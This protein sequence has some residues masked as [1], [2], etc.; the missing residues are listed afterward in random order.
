[1]H[2][3]V[4]S[5]GD[6]GISAQRLR[7]ETPREVT[8]FLETANSGGVIMSSE[9]FTPRPDISDSE[10]EH[11]LS[12]PY[13]PNGDEAD[14]FKYYCPLCMQYYK[15]IWR[16]QCCS[17][18]ICMPCTKDYMKAKGVVNFRIQIQAVPL[19]HVFCPHCQSIGF[20]PVVVDRQ[21]SIR[22]YRYSYEPVSSA[23]MPSPLKVGESFEDLKRKMIPFKA[24]TSVSSIPSSVLASPV[25]Q[26]VGSES[27]RQYEFSESQSLMRGIALA[28]EDDDVSPS[29]HGNR[30]VLT[31]FGVSPRE[32][33]FAN[34][35][36]LLSPFS[37][38]LTGKPSEMCEEKQTE[39]ND[40]GIERLTS[41]ISVQAT[42]MMKSSIGADSVS[43]FEESYESMVFSHLSDSQVFSPVSIS[44]ASP[45][46]QTKISRKFAINFVQGAIDSAVQHMKISQ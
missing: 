3:H 30:H 37:P 31:L 26:V 20:A 1:M 6:G 28:S 45:A 41:S 4:V 8:D 33:S 23:V 39:D 24:L 14:E 13:T 40:T 29:P 25:L 12:I 7:I 38:A 35:E 17:N 10:R 44:S 22:D 46:H 27:G 11:R 19:E 2:N 18:Y 21:E 16:S 5:T 43:I 15:H 9:K 42:P 36:D 32:E 34:P